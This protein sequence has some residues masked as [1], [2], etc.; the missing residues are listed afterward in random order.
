MWVADSATV[1]PASAF[2]FEAWIKLQQPGGYVACKNGSYLLTVG[3]SVS[4]E[5][6]VG[7]GW[8][9]LNGS[10]PISMGQ[11]THVAI[12]YDSSTKVAK[13]YVNGT[14]DNSMTISGGGNL[15]GYGSQLQLGQNDWNSMG[16]Q[17]DGKIDSV[18]I[19]S[20]ARAFDP[21][22][23][24]GPTPQAPIT[25]GNLVPNGDFEL[26]LNGWR[27]T[28]YGDIALCWETTGG[29]AKG[30][31]CLHSLPAAL[32]DFQGLRVAKSP[33]GLYSRPI[34][35][36]LGGH[37]KLSMRMK[38]SSQ[39]TLRVELDQAGGPLG[40]GWG[41]SP[42]PPYFA[43][44]PIWPT[45]GTG[46]TLVTQSF[47]V[48]TNLGAPSICV[49]LVYPSSGQLWVD[50]VEL[51]ADVVPNGL[52]LKDKVGVAPPTM[53]VGSLYLFGQASPMTLNVVNT[54]TVAHNVTIQPT[55]L[56]WEN[57]K[58]SGVPSL[59]TIN[60]PAGTV[61][62]TT[63]NID[64]SRRGTFRLGFDLT[65]ENQTWHQSTEVKYAVV[66]NMQNVGNADTSYFAMNTHQ[67]NEPSDHL[68]REMQV[69][70]TCGVKWIRAW[71][72]WGMC[73]K[74]IGTFDFTEYDR[75][76]NATTSGTGMRIMPILLRYYA[77][78]EQSW[79]GPVT[80]GA[81]QEYPYANELPEWSTW[82]GKVAQHY[83]GQIKAYE[84][85]NEPT[86]GSSPNGVLTSL[87][88]AN[89]L[90][91]TTPYL[92]QYDANAKLV[93]F[94]GT[95]LTGTTNA[96]VQGV[97]ALNTA[98]QMD[99]I[100][101]HAY[102]QTMVPEKNYPLEI[103]TGN[104]NLMSIMSAGGAGSKEIWHSEQGIP[105]DDDG[106]AAPASSEQDVTQLYVRNIITAVSLGSKHFFWFSS[107]NPPNAT[108]GLYYENY[109]PRQRLAALN[110]CASFI[111][112][113]AYQ[114]SYTLS[115]A[116]AYAH[117]FKGTS[118]VAVIWNTLNGMNVVLTGLSPAK[119]Q[120]FD[121]MGNSIT[122]GGTT[123]ATIQLASERPAYLQCALA[124]YSLLDSALGG[125]QVNASSPVVI[126]A[127]PV[128]GGVQVTLTGASSSPVDGT[129]G[130]VWAAPSQPTGWPA[131]QRFQSLASGQ[132][133]AFKFVLPNKAAVKQVSVVC[134]NRRLQTVTVPY[135]GR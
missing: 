84:L 75:Q 117:L 7:T 101:E 59:G 48:P 4:A 122:V 87:Q 124:D 123:D 13:I 108:M 41:M 8:Q 96:S 40:I 86:M 107:D 130:L 102:S 77:Q 23:V 119:V 106:Y 78:Y 70:S 21:I 33:P 26:G 64:T 17:V 45:I 90:N 28:S 46:W 103:K 129:V 85:W 127:G 134:G 66:V 32:P 20:V 38:A 31:K 6:N 80:S 16:S 29:A 15:S 72:G 58:I 89:L 100:S 56:D 10:L 116:G 128:V 105:G 110:A 115:N 135:S 14:L 65:S 74:T 44:F 94:A 95:P 63:Y 91:A 34:P 61:K 69:L 76:F 53:P 25:A 83:Q 97:L 47:T 132:S 71:W 55:I 111:E 73:E 11:W 24:S 67:E 1:R 49:L 131:A 54:D 9:S 43:P 126:A 42:T 133:Q 27:G 30:L 98:S 99:A 82:V 3:R 113:N 51:L 88:Y 118:A 35:V 39:I 50:D 81:I 62:T 104:P 121:T 18:R 114:K 93:A 36:R 5:F 120:A 19:S 68:A 22:P 92:R 2:T 60:V 37:Y 79:A 52:T 125:M 57:K 109:V 12:T 112:G